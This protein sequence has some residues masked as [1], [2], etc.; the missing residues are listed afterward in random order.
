MGKFH[1]SAVTKLSIYVGVLV[2]V[3][4]LHLVKKGGFG[5]VHKTKGREE[6]G[7]RFVGNKTTVISNQK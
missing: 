5:G 3:L 2:V 6:S 7:T 4:V 1:L